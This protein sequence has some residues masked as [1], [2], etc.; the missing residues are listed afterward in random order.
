M[1]VARGQSPTGQVLIVGLTESDVAQLRKGL[2]KTK[3]GNEA[4]GFS[5]LIVFMGKSDEEMVKLL[6]G[7]RTIRSDDVYPNSGQG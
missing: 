1:I 4:Y 7:E 5:S 6:S 2:T 3:Q